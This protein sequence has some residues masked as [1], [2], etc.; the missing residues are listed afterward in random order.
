MS[1]L[2]TSLLSS[3]RNSTHPVLA[4]HDRISKTDYIIPAR[5]KDRLPDVGHEYAFLVIKPMSCMRAIF[6][7]LDVA[8][9]CI[10]E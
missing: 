1:T 10:R 3:L 9:V 5:N 7:G 2:A 6:S 4:F 8:D